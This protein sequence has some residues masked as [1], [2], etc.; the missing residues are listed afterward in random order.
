M[1]DEITTTAN[2]TVVPDEIVAEVQSSLEK[3]NENAKT[4]QV[5]QEEVNK[6]TE[7]RDA[8]RAAQV[9]ELEDRVKHLES[10]GTPTKLAI[11]AAKAEMQRGNP[12]GYKS[13]SLLQTLKDVAG[14]KGKVTFESD[15]EREVDFLDTLDKEFLD[16]REKLQQGGLNNQGGY[17]VPEQFQP[18]LIKD[19]KAASVTSRAGVR[20][21]SVA[22]GT[23]TISY[24]K[25]TNAVST[26]WVAES[27]APTKTTLTFGALNA[28]A[29]KLAAYVPVT[30]S[31]IRQSGLSVE[32]IVREDFG[33]EMALAKD[34][35]VLRGAG[36]ANEPLGVANAA[37][38]GSVAIGT[39]GGQ[40]TYKKLRDLEY[41]VLSQNVMGNRLGWIT[42][43][44]VWNQINKILDGDSRPL[45]DQNRNTPPGPDLRADGMLHNHP[46]YT[47]TQL[48]TN[49]TKGVGTS[50]SEIY[51]GDWWEML[52]FEFSSLE[53]RVFDQ[54]WDNTNSHNAALQDL[55]FFVVFY[56]M[57]TLIRHDEAFALTNDVA[58]SD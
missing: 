22:P 30:R 17:L 32:S 19:F 54:A 41:T 42:H 44:A 16:A 18:E 29:K 20:E 3:M 28:T 43:P 12:D 33:V 14:A 39:D 48:P 49:L 4:F 40:P 7:E 36:A 23:G 10:R 38:I 25:K 37:S 11:A 26:Y 21:V 24:P 31:L 51:F 2:G 34:L 47:T 9:Q 56:E 1:A 13:A 58:T 35:A 5:S 50:L 55:L 8:K 53:I 45:Y 27:G 52:C 6:Q 46:L 57:D 15:Q